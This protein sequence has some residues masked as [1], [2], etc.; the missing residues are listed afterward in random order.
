MEKKTVL[1]NNGEKLKIGMLT[2]RNNHPC[3]YLKKNEVEIRETRKVE[4]NS[5]LSNI[6]KP[7]KKE[8]IAYVDSAD[9]KLIPCKI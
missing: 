6:F 5:T 9:N 7:Q 1:R 8:E 3:E 2:G 4:R